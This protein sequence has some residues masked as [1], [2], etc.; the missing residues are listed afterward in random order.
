MLMIF[1]NFFITLNGFCEKSEIKWHSKPD[2][3]GQMGCQE[4]NKVDR[5]Y[6]VLFTICQHPIGEYQPIFLLTKKTLRINYRNISY[7]T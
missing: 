2:L 7:C 4:I 6:T 1:E 3:A 5:D